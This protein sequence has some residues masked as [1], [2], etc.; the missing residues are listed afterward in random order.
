V[1][2]IRRDNEIHDEEGDWFGPGDHYRDPDND[3]F[4]AM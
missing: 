1:I 2:E 4:G 3:G